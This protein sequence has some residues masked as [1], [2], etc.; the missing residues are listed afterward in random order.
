MKVSVKMASTPQT[1]RALGLQP[2]GKAQAFHTRNV[3]NRITKYMPYK[4]NGSVPKA[5][6]AGVDLE[7]NQI[8]VR[9]PHVRYLNEGKVMVGKKPKRATSKA[10]Q[11]TTST[12]KLAGPHW[13][14]RLKEAEGAAMTADLQRYLK[15]GGQA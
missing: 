3:A 15:T 12:N 8:V 4:L 1:I 10:L 14:R 6:L 13:A 11:Y 9:G 2:G 5:A 7:R